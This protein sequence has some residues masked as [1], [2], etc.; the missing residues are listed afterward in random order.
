MKTQDHAQVLID[1]IGK[2]SAVFDAHNGKYFKELLRLVQH[3]HR[4]DAEQLSRMTEYQEKIKRALEKGA[5]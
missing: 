1:L 5:I 2:A 3:G 4:L